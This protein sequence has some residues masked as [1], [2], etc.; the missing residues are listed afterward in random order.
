MLERYDA[1]PIKG[2][3]IT[4]GDCFP[5]IYISDRDEVLCYPGIYLADERRRR[6]SFMH[7]YYMQGRHSTDEQIAKEIRGFYRFADGCVVLDNYVD[8]RLFNDRTYK[9]APE[10]IRFPCPDTYYAVMVDREEDLT[11][12]LFGLTYEEL[13]SLLEAYAKVMGTYTE[14]VTYPK[15]TRSIHS[16]IFCDMI[17]VWIPERFPYIAFNVRHY[18]FS[19]VSL[20][21]FYRHVKLLTGCKMRTRFS[22]LLLKA[23]AAEDVLKWLFTVGNTAC[24]QTKVVGVTPGARAI[25]RVKKSIVSRHK[26]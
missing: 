24:Y 7:P 18:T 11:R 21:G 15:L 4:I 25:F 22:R 9:R 19:H 12:T 20:W 10:G 17:G 8:N 2:K 5:E 6:T 1:E 13:T 3:D 26:I 14:Y 23:G 16:E